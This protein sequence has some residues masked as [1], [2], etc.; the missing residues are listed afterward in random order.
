VAIYASWALSYVSYLLA[1]ERHFSYWYRNNIGEFWLL[2]M[3]PPTVCTAVIFIF[4]WA[5]QE[6]GN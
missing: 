6:K 5:A 2:L 1:T 3:L 4:R